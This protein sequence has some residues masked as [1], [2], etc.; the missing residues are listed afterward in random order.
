MATNAV[1]DMIG[2]V[3]DRRRPNPASGVPVEMLKT[4]RGG[5][6]GE[7]PVDVGAARVE[8]PVLK[9][10]CRHITVEARKRGIHGIRNTG[11]HHMTSK[12]IAKMI[13]D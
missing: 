7:R 9:R 2:K 8:N 1:I 13:V 4:C 5:G 3:A 11:S 12:N 6:K 10:R